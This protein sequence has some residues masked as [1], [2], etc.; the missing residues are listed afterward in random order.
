MF[1]NKKKSKKFCREYN[2]QGQDSKEQS[3]I[4]RITESRVD[5]EAKMKDWKV[6]FAVG[7]YEY[8]Y[9]VHAINKSMFQDLHLIAVALFI[10]RLVFRDAK[11]LNDIYLSVEKSVQNRIERPVSEDEDQKILAEEKVIRE[12]TPES[13]QELEEKEQQPPQEPPVK[14]TNKRKKK[15]D[16]N[17]KE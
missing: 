2:L 4:L 17:R 1:K 12:Q 16:E 11:V 3:F 14:K 15:N 6:M 8:S 7:T 5:I 13:I 9:I 10:S